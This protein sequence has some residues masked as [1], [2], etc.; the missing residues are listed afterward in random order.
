MTDTR[1]I[2][3][4][5]ITN[6]P[7]SEP[8]LELIIMK[9]KG[10]KFIQG[11]ALAGVFLAGV[12][13]SGT[14]T[15][16]AESGGLAAAGLTL[17]TTTGEI[18]GT[19]SAS[20]NVAFTGT[21]TD[22]AA[23]SISLTFS[24]DVISQLGFEQTLPG[25]TEQ[26]MAYSYQ[27]KITGATGAVTYAVTS[28]TL[29]SGTS[30]SSGGMLSGAVGGSPQTYVFTVTATDGGTGQTL[31]IPCSVLVNIKLS[32]QLGP[33][34]AQI[35]TNVPTT[36]PRSG[37]IGFVGGVAPFKITVHSGVIVP[38]GLTIS[39]STGTGGI[40]F[41][42]S[43]PFAG[44]S[45]SFDVTDAIGA[46]ITTPALSLT[47]LAAVPSADAGN[48]LS[49]GTDGALYSSSG[50]GGAAQPDFV[51]HTITGGSLM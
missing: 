14:Y 46:S 40:T 3:L 43:Q 27:F 12:G 19:P 42:A 18:T 44:A 37:K 10:S 8:P 13:G 34:S 16:Y 11:I 25:P 7:Q 39:P 6:N 30:L 15:A 36:L 49:V 2:T 32:A 47:A 24:F 31:N 41:T 45:L 21:V 50:G 9:P 48:A 38:T 26:G 22:S 23:N 1:P 28:G 17:N 33:F 20:G 29:P 5:S 4:V 35:V 51:V